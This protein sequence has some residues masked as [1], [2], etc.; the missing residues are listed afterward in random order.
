MQKKRGRNLTE[1][2]YK[3]AAQKL[4]ENT[5]FTLGAT[6]SAGRPTLAQGALGNVFMLFKRFAVSKYYMMYKNGKGKIGTTNISKI[7]IKKG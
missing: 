2:D 4:V 5:E 6:A 3:E 1:D 7:M